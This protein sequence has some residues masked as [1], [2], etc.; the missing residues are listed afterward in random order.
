MT[1]QTAAPAILVLLKARCKL[2]AVGATGCSFWPFPRGHW[3]N[4]Q[5]ESSWPCFYWPNAKGWESAAGGCP[6]PCPPCPCF[7]PCFCPDSPFSGYLETSQALSWGNFTST[8]LTQNFWWEKKD[9]DCGWSSAIIRSEVPA[10]IPLKSVLKIHFEC[11][12]F[13]FFPLAASRRIYPAVL[14]GN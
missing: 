12:L 6:R 10:A 13:F 2:H 5:R 8:K 11:S 3:L 14:L 1:P 7:C 4:K 9:D